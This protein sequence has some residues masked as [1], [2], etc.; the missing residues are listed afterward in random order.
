[1][2]ANGVEIPEP[3]PLDIFVAVMGEE[4][5]LKGQGILHD[6]H[7]AG[8]SAQM[9][10][11]SRNLK[12]QFKYAARLGAR[13][14]VVI[15]DDEIERGVVQLKGMDAHEQAEIPFDTIVDELK[16]RTE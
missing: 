9:D 1:M 15:G 10:I 6:L 5:K 2:E 4:A 12:G 14:T 7:L 8:I 11:L 13:Y 3:E 16:K